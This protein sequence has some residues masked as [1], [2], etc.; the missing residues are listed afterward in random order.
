MS[1]PEIEKNIPIPGIKSKYHFQD[2]KVGDSMLFESRERAA[3]QAARHHFKKQGWKMA[4]R[5]T[6]QGLRIWRIE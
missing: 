5:S 1:F 3:E 6:P 4:T 2:M